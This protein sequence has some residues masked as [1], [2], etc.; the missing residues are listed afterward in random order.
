[1]KL[2]LQAIDEI[3]G[4][5][6]Q[7]VPHIFFQ[8]ENQKNAA[9]IR[10]ENYAAKA[11]CARCPIKVECLTYALESGEAYGIWGGLLPSER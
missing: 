5:E 3:G 11:I 9:V 7:Q 6:C 8:E 2:L 4:A 1:M 10:E